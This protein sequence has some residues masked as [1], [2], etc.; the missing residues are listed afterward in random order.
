MKK[1]GYIYLIVNLANGFKYIGQ[2]KGEFTPYYFGSGIYIKKA[3]KKYTKVN[4]KVEPIDYAITKEGLDELEKYWISHHNSISPNGYNLTKGGDG[5]DLLTYNPR[6]AEIIQKSAQTRKG[7]KRPPFSKEWKENIRLAH[8]GKKRS[9][10]T[11]ETKNK[12][13]H[14][15]RKLKPGTPHIPNCACGRCKSIR[16]ET[17][18]K[19]HP[20]FGIHRSEET[21]N[22]IR[23]TLAITRSQ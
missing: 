21:K 11:E 10:H 20:L 17:K 7:M 8:L 4:F 14:P 19:N 1:Y 2:K 16:G 6:R 9:P 23:K 22:K 13:R 5:G 3:I 12:M 18:G 15:H